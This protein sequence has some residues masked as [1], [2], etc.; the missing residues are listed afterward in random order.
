MVCW[1]RLLLFAGLVWMGKAVEGYPFLRG[2]ALASWKL[3]GTSIVCSKSQ[4][5][6]FL[7]YTLPEDA[8]DVDCG[9]CEEGRKGRLVRT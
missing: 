8:V 3:A 9:S 2:R 1:V 7:C 4:A 6:A 5:L